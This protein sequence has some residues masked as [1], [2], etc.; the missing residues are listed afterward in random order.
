M[1]A[2]QSWPE[3]RLVSLRR[4]SRGR[5]SVLVVFRAY[6]GCLLPKNEILRRD[7]DLFHRVRVLLH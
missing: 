7:F 5:V 3:K 6:I 4:S 1:A 2:F